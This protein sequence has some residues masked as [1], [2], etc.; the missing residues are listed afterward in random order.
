MLRDILEK[1]YIFETR[2]IAMNK[3]LQKEMDLLQKRSMTK[4]ALKEQR[5]QTR[6]FWSTRPSV[7][8]DKRRSKIEKTKKREL[9]EML[10]F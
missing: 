8:D 4:K 7:I 3:K 2:K 6:K 10:A 1:K 9:R 5:N